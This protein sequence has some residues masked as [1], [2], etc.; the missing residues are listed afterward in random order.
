MAVRMTNGH[1]VAPQVEENIVFKKG[2]KRP[3]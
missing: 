2:E 1:E 3:K